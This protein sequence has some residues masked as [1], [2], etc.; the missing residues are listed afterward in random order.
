MVAAKDPPRGRTA[1]VPAG[2]TAGGGPAVRRRTERS[3]VPMFSTPLPPPVPEDGPDDLGLPPRYYPA[4]EWAWYLP[5]KRAA[6]LAATVLLLVPA[7]PLVALA[8]LL[9][10]LTSRGPAVY[11][12]TRLGRFGRPYTIY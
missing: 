5:V 8:A 9:V 3:L 12:Q 7:L 4:P 2:P 6:E 1:T 10:K 11:S